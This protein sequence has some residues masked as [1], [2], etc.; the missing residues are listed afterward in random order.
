LQQKKFNEALAKFNQYVKTHPKS[1][2][3]VNGVAQC[4]DATHKMAEAIINYTKLS[5]LKCGKQSDAA[6][7][8]LG[9]LYSKNKQPN[10]AKKV[11]QKAMQ[12]KY[13]DIAEQAKKELDKL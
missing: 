3:A 5:Q 12:S 2:E 7:L 9:E 4:Y 10:E 1:C 8:K 13:L 11:L 6:Y